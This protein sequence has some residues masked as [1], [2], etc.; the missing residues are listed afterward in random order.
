MGVYAQLYNSIVIN[1]NQFEHEKI[2]CIVCG[3]NSDPFIT[4]EGDICFTCG[5][6][7]HFNNLKKETASS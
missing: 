7:E 2:K 6:D 1:P 5:V 4:F 3:E